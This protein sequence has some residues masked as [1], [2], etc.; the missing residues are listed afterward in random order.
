MRESI[1]LDDLLTMNPAGSDESKWFDEYIEPGALLKEAGAR[2]QAEDTYEHGNKGCRVNILDGK[3]AQRDGMGDRFL[4]ELDELGASVLQ[5]RERDLPLFLASYELSTGEASVGYPFFKGPHAL[6]SNVVVRVPVPICAAPL[7]YPDASQAAHSGDPRCA[8]VRRC[9]VDHVATDDEAF[10]NYHHVSAFVDICGIRSGCQ[11]GKLEARALHEMLTLA[12]ADLSAFEHGLPYLSSA[13]CARA[14][15]PAS[16]AVQQ[17]YLDGTGFGSPQAYAGHVG[18]LVGGSGFKRGLTIGSA[19][20]VHS[21]EKGPWYTLRNVDFTEVE[22]S[23][24]SDGHN[25]S[26]RLSRALSIAGDRLEVRCMGDGGY[27][28]FE[29][30]P[31]QALRTKANPYTRKMPNK[32]KKS[33]RWF[34]IN[35]KWATE[36][37][38]IT[39]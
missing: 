10:K 11:T 7:Q 13:L 19:D 2:A 21:V 24:Q 28:T 12:G 27:A 17:A 30:G 34:P 4:D 18:G 32:L 35:Y 8:R 6:A 5:V 14:G 20:I 1:K 9:A 26:L 22:S 3:K 25:R 36:V 16:V 39:I 31:K 33:V 29:F 38:S 15:G 37:K 23:G